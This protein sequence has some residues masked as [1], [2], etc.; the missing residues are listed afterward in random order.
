MLERNRVDEFAGRFTAFHNELVACVESCSDEDWRK[1]CA[2][3][4]WTV[5]V[6][7][8]HIADHYQGCLGLAKRVVTGEALPDS[9]PGAIHQSNAQR[10]QERAGCTQD[11][12]LRVLLEAGASISSFV[13]GL[14]DADLDRTGYSP[15]FGGEL[16]AQ[17]AIE[18][19]IGG[20][21]LD[22]IKAATGA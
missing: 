12:V 4:E 13:A 2:G 8:Y 16:S 7:A 15:T 18:L 6:V 22:S 11:E 14:S 9:A 21:H 10:A 5:G 19:T 1:V 3:E 20:G 17:R